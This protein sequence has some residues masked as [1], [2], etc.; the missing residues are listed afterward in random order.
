MISLAYLLH[1]EQIFNSYGLAGLVLAATSF[2]Q[3]LAGPLTS[4]WMGYWGMRP[5]I[6]LT[7]IVSAFSM[8][9]IAFVAMPIGAYI[10]VGFVGGLATL[11]IQS[12]VRTI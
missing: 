12:A 5:V 2:G 6:I 8:A 3:A 11:P 7:I 4:R 1:I 9:G 10:A